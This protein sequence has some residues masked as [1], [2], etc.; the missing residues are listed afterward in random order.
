MKKIWHF[1]QISIH[2]CKQLEVW[3]QFCLLEID[4][5]CI[6]VYKNVSF[7]NTFYTNFT[8]KIDFF[9]KQIQI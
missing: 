3:L 9:S 5:A 7:V 1:Y 2:A 8:Y 6:V 4:S